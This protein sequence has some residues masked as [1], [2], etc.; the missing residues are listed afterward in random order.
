MMKQTM[1]PTLI[2][3]LVLS[4][5]LADTAETFPIIQKAYNA[6]KIKKRSILGKII[7]EKAAFG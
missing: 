7:H 3:D 4:F 1:Y 5:R 6:L 2:L